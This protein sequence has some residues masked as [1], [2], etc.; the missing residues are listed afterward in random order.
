MNDN[1]FTIE[2]QGR[3]SY[4][5]EKKY[6]Y[7]ERVISVNEFDKMEANSIRSVAYTSVTDPDVSARGQICLALPLHKTEYHPTDAR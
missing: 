7:F 1:W 4:K 6:I 3:I 2:G 5:L